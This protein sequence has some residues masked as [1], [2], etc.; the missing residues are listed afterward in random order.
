MYGKN[1]TKVMTR[2]QFSRLLNEAWMETMKPA[3]ICAGFRASGVYPFNLNAVHC[4]DAVINDSSPH[5]T[6][7]STAGE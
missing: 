7:M 4:A 5:S 3:S 2:Y 6:S 1:R